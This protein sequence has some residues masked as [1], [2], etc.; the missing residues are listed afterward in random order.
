MQKRLGRAA[1]RRCLRGPR[2]FRV[3]VFGASVAIAFALGGALAAQQDLSAK[4]I[5]KITIQ[6]LKKVP[7][8]ELLYRLGEKVRYGQNYDP[9]AVSE[10]SGKLFLTGY[11]SE[12]K[13]LPP[14]D[15]EDG[16]EVVFYVEERMLVTAVQ[17]DAEDVSTR[18][19]S[20]S[21]TKLKDAVSTKARGRL[22][23]FALE[24]DT[25]Q[26][27]QT[28]Q[29]EGYLFAEVTAAQKTT[30]DGVQVTFSIKEGPRVRVHDITFEGNKS[31]NASTL[32]RL[33]GT[34]TKDWFFG[35]FNP[36]FYDREE[37]AQDI[38]KLR[39]YYHGMGFFEASVAVAGVEF[40]DRNRRLKIRV[41]IEEGPR[42]VFTGYKIEGNSVFQTA[43]LLA[44]SQARPGQ[45]FSSERMERDRGEILK[46]YKDRAFI[47]AK[48]TTITIPPEKGT[49]VEV[50][51]KIEEGHE[52]YIDHVHIRG[53]IKTQD[54]VI[55]RELEFYPGERFNWFQQQKS[56]SNLARLRYFSSV[57]YEY[58][59]TS[60]PNRRDVVVKVEEEPTGRL[61]LGFGVTS[62]F[63]VIGNFAVTKRNF[64]LADL[65]E[66]IYEI[67]D[68]FTGAGQN[69]NI[70]LQPGT[71]RSFY[72]FSFTEPYL[73]ETR[74]SLTLAAASTKI[75]REDYDEDRLSFKP[76]LSHAFDFDRDLVF[77][78]GTRLEEVEISD[79][80][81]ELDPS[82]TSGIPPDVVDVEGF[83][84]VIGASAGLNYDKVLI[85]PLEGPYDGHQEWLAYEWAG[86][87][88]G[89]E[90]DISKLEGS[91]ALYFPIHEH[92]EDRLHHVLAFYTKFGVIEGHHNTESVPIFERFFLGGPN[93]VRGFRFR[94]LG[95][96]TRL[97]DPLGGAAAW[98]GN[99][100]YVFPL[101]Q[102]Y[103]RGVIFLD[104]GNLATEPSAFELDEMRFAAGGGIR[105]NFPFLG[106]PLP[107][108]LYLGNA[109]KTEDPDRKRAFLFTIGTPF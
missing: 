39:A 96:H 11:F 7:E 29:E 58:P 93:T 4:K 51:F 30:D 94:G 44:L 24:M 76:S 86:P 42:Y 104:Y 45:F 43:T 74:N 79:I 68:S 63:G 60:A 28:Y 88:L 9:I 12:V 97:K 34:K 62:G 47:D 72:Q 100:E 78:I 50:H 10:A 92:Q 40:S 16:V 91:L 59:S 54:R 95:P 89:G 25:Q 33:M 84:S 98:Y 48:V 53:N 64:D 69:L 3:A 17:F 1:L 8:A 90:V 103:I 13:V 105:M 106:Q 85:E 101:F 77:S 108:G 49:T 80:D 27:V 87:P 66:S 75:I 15:Y 26:L 67:P 99:I 107:I 57:D 31:V 73:F 22:A 61:L 20:L 71:R 18:K 37:L 19:P 81:R 83:N 36:G 6:N 32:L 52:I 82:K 35:L 21:Q 23:P 46:Y 14:R 55:R 41:I 109:F 2:Q 65:P 5:R 38:E 102:K 70:V 56:R